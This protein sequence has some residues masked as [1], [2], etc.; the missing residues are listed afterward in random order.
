MCSIEYM[1]ETIQRLENSVTDYQ[2]GI[3]TYPTVLK[4]WKEPLKNSEYD[5]RYLKYTISVCGSMVLQYTIKINKIEQAIKEYKDAIE[6]YPIILR[7]WQYHL[8][9]VKTELIDWKSELEKTSHL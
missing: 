6:S 2:D 1:R 3:D 9:K 4:S 7:A 8:E 5:L